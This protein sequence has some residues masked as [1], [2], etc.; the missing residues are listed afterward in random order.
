MHS[1]PLRVYA[2]P[3]PSDGFG[4]STP[5]YWEIWGFGKKQLPLDIHG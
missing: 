4:G 1:C 2:S 5:K 3:K